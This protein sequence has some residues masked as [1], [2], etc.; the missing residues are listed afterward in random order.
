MPHYPETETIFTHEDVKDLAGRKIKCIKWGKGNQISP[1][2]EVW[3]GEVSKVGEESI[4]VQDR[5]GEERQA[6]ISEI[7]ELE[8]A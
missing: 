5:T 8:L 2:H 4:T 1:M 6:L 7:S 3:G